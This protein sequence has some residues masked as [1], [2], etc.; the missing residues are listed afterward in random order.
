MTGANVTVAQLPTQ[1]TMAS[2]DSV[3]AWSATGGYTYQVFAT[4]ISNA[5][6][7][8]RTTATSGTAGVAALPSGPVGFV[9]IPLG[10]ATVKIP[11]Y[12]T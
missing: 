4:Q 5:A 7:Q 10:T 2:G 6:F 9:I 11:Y 1:T 8:Y 3:W 12:A